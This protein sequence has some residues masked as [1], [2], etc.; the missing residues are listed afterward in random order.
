MAVVNDSAA[1]VGLSP[2]DFD[3]PFFQNVFEETSERIQMPEARKSVTWQSRAQPLLSYSSGGNFLAERRRMGTTYLLG[4]SLDNSSGNFAR[5]ALFVPVMYK[6]AASSKAYSSELYKF[7]SE[8]TFTYRHDSASINDLY[9]LVRGDQRIIPEQRIEGKR[10]VFSVPR[11][12]ISS[13]FYD[14]YYGDNL[15]GRLAFN[16]DPQESDIRQIPVDGINE[17]YTGARLQR[18]EGESS[19]RFASAVSERYVGR[20][21]WRE[22]LILAMLFFLAEVLLVRFMP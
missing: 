4:A 6:I 5:H 10:V 21:L 22:A 1:L 8:T 13:G 17:F 9:A 15:K 11:F 14:L 2:P 7:T 3:N 12:I 20:P 16:L 19:E 18:L